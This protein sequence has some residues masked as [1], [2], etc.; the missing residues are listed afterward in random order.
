MSEKRA[1]VG[2]GNELL[3][4]VGRLV[5]A[6]FCKGNSVIPKERVLFLQL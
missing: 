2:D 1:A 4:A 3:K 5:L 6:R